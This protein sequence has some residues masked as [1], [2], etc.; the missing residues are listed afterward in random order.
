MTK[1]VYENEKVVE[2]D[3]LDL[4]LLEISL[5]HGIPHVHEWGGNARCSTCRVI[6]L[7]SLENTLPRNEAEKKLAKQK[8]LESNIRLACQTKISGPVKLRRL[9]RDDIDIKMI[10]GNKR[11]TGS[12]IQAAILF[13]DVRDFTEFAESHLSYDT[14][15]I[16]NRYFY[17]V[18]EAILKYHGYIDKYMGDGVMAL[19]GLPDYQSSGDAGSICLNAVSAGLAILEALHHFNQRLKDDFNTEFKIGVGIHFGDVL[20]G[21]M[22]HP[23]IMQ[24]TAIG[25]TV[26]TASRIESAT[27]TT[28]TSLLISQPV[29]E[30]IRDKIKIGKTVSMELKGKTGKHILYEVLNTR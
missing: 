23:D 30:P 1:V 13:C 14:I 28:Q 12:E 29:L 27:K 5:K 21:E 9:T 7:E 15:H 8:G 20:V 6:I 10:A 22:G 19:F 11:S 4:T 24:Y 3:D 2:E 17:H 25:D 26:N 16:L 18:G